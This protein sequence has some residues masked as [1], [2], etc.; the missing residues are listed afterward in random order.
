MTLVTQC[1]GALFLVG[2]LNT[3]LPP[4][5]L[6]SD[7]VQWYR[8]SNGPDGGP[9]FTAAGTRQFECRKCNFGA[10]AGLY[11]DPAG[12]LLLYS[13][14]H[15]NRGP[16]ESVQFEEFFPVARGGVASV[17]DAWAEFYDDRH[18]DDLTF[19]LEGR[20]SSAAAA[21][22]L[23][24]RQRNRVTSVRWTLPPGWRLR[25]FADPGCDGAH[26]DLTGTGETD[27]LSTLG[28][29]DRLACARWLPDPALGGPSP[30]NRPDR[31]D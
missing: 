3:A 4:P 15:S 30:T 24:P 31:K 6:G 23:P 17:A 26:L 20:T 16:E 1:D 14:E 13:V 8:L 18:F 22:A 9:L 27:D 7:V 21:V 10:G 11:I 19:R 28:F 5:S 29:D 12:A 25:L 2:T